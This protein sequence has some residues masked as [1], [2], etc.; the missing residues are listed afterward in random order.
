MTVRQDPIDVRRGFGNLTGKNLFGG[1][2]TVTQG[3]VIS[4]IPQVLL[5]YLYVMVNSIF[6][7]R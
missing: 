5:S 1:T 6:T 2:L 3:A 7:V 4:N